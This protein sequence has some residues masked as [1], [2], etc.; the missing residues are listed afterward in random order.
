[1]PQIAASELRLHCLFAIISMQI[2]IKVKTFTRKPQKLEIYPSKN[3]DGQ[4]PLVKKS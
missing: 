4:A 1:M 3:K 2:I